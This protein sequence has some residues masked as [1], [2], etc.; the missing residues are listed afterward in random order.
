MPIRPI[1]HGRHAEAGI[2]DEGMGHII[3]ALVVGPTNMR[4]FARQARRVRGL[5]AVK[6]GPL[7]RIVQ[8]TLA[9]GLTGKVR[10]KPQD[11]WPQ[12]PFFRKTQGHHM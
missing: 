5:L 2:V 7:S 1:H 12:T 3:T 9:V 8:S 10:A 6:S 4:G 11:Q